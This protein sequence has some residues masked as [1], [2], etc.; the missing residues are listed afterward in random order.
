[1]PDKSNSNWSTTHEAWSDGK[2]LWIRTAI[3]YYNPVTDETTIEYTDPYC[4]SSWKAAA[5]GVMTLKERIDNA[6]K[7]IAQLEKEVD[8]AIETWFMEG[9]PNE[10]ENYPWYDINSENQDAPAEHEGDLYFDT[11][12][13]KSYRFF[14]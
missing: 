7:L 14:K 5:D 8:G 10:L 6:D 2:Y 11:T 13:G 3:T 12:S 9:N 4:D 1:V